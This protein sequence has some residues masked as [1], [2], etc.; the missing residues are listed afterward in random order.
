MNGEQG[1]GLK[2][3]DLIQVWIGIA[4][5][6]T[7][8]F[9]WLTYRITKGG[10]FLSLPHV[11]VTSNDANQPNLVWLSLS[12]ANADQWEITT[13]FVKSPRSVWLLQLIEEDDGRG[14]GAWKIGKP[15]G[16]SVPYPLG[17]PIVLSSVEEPVRL[18]IK[19]SLKALP[20]VTSWRTAT[21]NKKD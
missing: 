2:V 3:A 10:F 13:V 5:S 8:L 11:V 21:I 9:T 19:L 7:A 17:A 20:S 15:I 12:G 18:R 16:R 1:A 4:I 6:I 14:G